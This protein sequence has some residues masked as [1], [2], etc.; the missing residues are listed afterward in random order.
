MKYFDSHAHYYDERFSEELTEGVDKL[1][2]TL[3]LENVSYILNIGTS[4]ETSR[5]AVR[6]AKKYSN[7]YT[8]I[9][10]HP[11]DTRFLSDIDSELSEIEAMILDKTNKCVC[12]GEIGLDYHYPDTD[13]EKQHSYFEAQM[14]L[15]ERLNLPVCIHDRDAH[16]DVM[17]VIR[18]YPGVR[19]VLHSYSGSVE[20]A[21]ELVS[22]G[23]MISFSG[24][25][26]FKNARRPVE[27]AAVMPRERVLIETDA[28]Y[29]APHP[30]RG[31]LNH[32]GNLEYTNARLAEIWGITPEECAEITENNAKRFFGI[33][34]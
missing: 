26:T 12:L 30:K 19:G 27:V 5:E 29:L 6:Q 8:A 34:R 33:D 16:E 10:I 7:M 15:A 17:A 25:L 31:S 20:M 22:L 9:G 32:S 18:R 24:T 23:Y 13:K 3:L 11:S 2:D 14:Q 28:P 21:K 1:I 4:P